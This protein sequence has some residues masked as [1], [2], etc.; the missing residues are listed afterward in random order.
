[1]GNTRNSQTVPSHSDLPGDAIMLRRYDELF[2]YME[3]FGRGDLNLVLLLGRPGTGKTAAAKRILAQ[4]DSGQTSED[5]IEPLYVEGHAQPYGLYH[6]LWWHRDQPVVLDDLD[7]LYAR[8][9]CVRLLK[10][11]CNNQRIKRLSWLSRTIEFADGVPATFETKSNVLLIANEWKS[12]N[13]NVRALE[14]RA[15]VLHF[16]PSHEEIHRYVATWFEDSQVLE[17]A[18]EHLSVAAYLSIRC[19]EKACALRGA[20]V[21]EWRHIMLQMMMPD[22]RLALVAALQADETCVTEKERVERF[23]IETGLSRPTYYRLKRL[24][25]L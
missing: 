6:Q 25:K 14:D 7:G 11:L 12:L 17:F 15:I 16:D 1:M 4:P 21:D 24:L 22:R 2:R 18:D 19:Y 23:S 13:A 20:G 9:D 10:A 5:W 3:M 8:P